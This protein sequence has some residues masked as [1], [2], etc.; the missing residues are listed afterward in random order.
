LKSRYFF[1]LWP[2]D[3]IRSELNTLGDQLTDKLVKR[4]RIENLHL[5]LVFPGNVDTATMDEII[6]EVS[7]ESTQAFTL[8]IDR[9]GWWKKPAITW[10]AP[11]IVPDTLN[12]VVSR[13]DQIC[14]KHAI[15]LGDRPYQPHITLARK[16]TRATHVEKF[17]PVVWKVTSF[18]LIKSVT[19][20]SGPEYQP[21]ES[22]S[23]LDA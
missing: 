5:T 11:S 7:K 3:G 4:T 16:S 6:T 12:L 8:E 15:E 18:S 1:A 20:A 22:W 23:L 14:R 13:L 2:D 19:W 17:Q 21:V 9:L 10:A